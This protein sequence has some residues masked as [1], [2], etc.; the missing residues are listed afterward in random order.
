MHH[1]L[2]RI[3]AGA[4]VA[5]PMLFGAST[6]DA[7]GA[8]TQPPINNRA[9]WGARSAPYAPFGTTGTYT[10]ACVHHTAN[11]GD[12][13]I[14]TLDQGKYRVRVTQDYHMLTLGW[15][16]IAY[17]FLVDKLGNAY[18]GLNG[19]LS[20]TNLRGAHDAI[21]NASGGFNLLGWFDTGKNGSPTQVQLNRLYDVIAWR[22]PSAWSPYGSGAYGGYSVIGNLYGHYQVSSKTCPGTTVQPLIGTNYSGGTMRNEIN[23]RIQSG[24][25]PWAATYQANTFVPT[26]RTGQ[27]ATVGV[28]FKNTGTS[29]WNSMTRLATSNPR[30]R[31]SAFYTGGDWTGIDRPTALDQASVA[32]NANGTFTFVGT[33]PATTGTYEEQFELVQDGTSWFEATGD[34]VTWYCTVE[35]MPQYEA[36]YFSN[37]FPTTV[38]AGQSVTVSVTYKN[39]GSAT[40]NSNTRLGTSEPR[41]RNSAFHYSTDWLGANRPTAVDATTAPNANGTFTFVAKA[42]MTPGQYEENFEVLQ[43]GVAWFNNSG[44]IWFVN[45][46]A[47]TP[48]AAPTGLVLT[49]GDGGVG[50]DWNNNSES[51]LSGYNVYRS[52]TIAGTYTKLNGALLTTSAYNNTGTTNGTVYF[53]KVGAVDSVGQE[54]L[55]AATVAIPHANDY[56]KLEAEGYGTGGAG[57]SFSDSDAGN[58]GGVIRTDDVDLL[59]TANATSIG[60]IA[61]NEWIKFGGLYGTGT[62]YRVRARVASA[63][64]GGSFNVLINGAVA[65]SVSWPAATGGWDTWTVVNGPL[66]TL[67]TGPYTVQIT[68]TSPSWNLDWV[69]F[70]QDSKVVNDDAGAP[71]FAQTGTWT[72]TTTA[73]FQGFD[74]YAYAGG[75]HTAT[76]NLDVPQTGNYKVEVIFRNGTN[77]ATSAKHTINRA[78]GSNIVYVDQKNT[79]NLTWVNLGTFAF[80]AGTGSVVLDAAGSTGG[81][82]VMADCIRITYVP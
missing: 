72:N 79:A 22:M 36:T 23:A 30:G 51:D 76:W 28:T 45:V 80:N 78:G 4:A 17:H 31:S 12:F 10:R 40:W 73:G 3:L 21:N 68:M 62:S 8:A 60:W 19:S 5:A 26:L 2:S 56:L 49:N 55:T 74:R 27:Q 24:G 13:N 53:Y 46:I 44:V 34:N 52:G 82:V 7:A 48:P 25:G 67:P 42:P 64:N 37:T 59:S 14:T 11:T 41:D 54:T 32:P 16:D 65:G 43:E 9:A 29:T 63:T 81:T 77:R 15:S 20:A 66:V 50:L 57:V 35:P 70:T 6:A 18:E 69:D 71:G 58:T 47:N 38:T 1:L 61:A 75:A 33:A 39:T